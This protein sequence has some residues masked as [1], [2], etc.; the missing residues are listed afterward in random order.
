MAGRKLHAWRQA[1]H[2]PLGRLRRR[3]LSGRGFCSCL[4]GRCVVAAKYDQRENPSQKQRAAQQGEPTRRAWLVG[5]EVVR[6]RFRLVVV[7]VTGVGRV[8]VF[9]TVTAHRPLM[10]RF[11]ARSKGTSP[12]SLG[13]A[14]GTL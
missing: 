12:R 13:E 9:V 7:V 5:G 3:G 1:L 4:R 2:R 6:G 11:F 10:S 8:G 14:C